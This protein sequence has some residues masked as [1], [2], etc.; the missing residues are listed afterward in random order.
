M[1]AEPIDLAGG[2]DETSMDGLSV[3]APH[4]LS[5][6]PSLAAESLHSY[7]THRSHLTVHLPTALDGGRGSF[8][9]GTGLEGD[10]A[11]EPHQPPLPTLMV[12]KG[13]QS[14]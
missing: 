3:T 2:D 1:L 4:G 9:D 13:T 14:T 7:T 5:V 11:T 6:S 10:Q 12:S 8:T